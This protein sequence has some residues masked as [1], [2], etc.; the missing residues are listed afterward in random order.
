MDAV[1]IRNRRVDVPQETAVA[2]DILNPSRIRE[3][4]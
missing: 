4:L 1:I 2:P 3:E